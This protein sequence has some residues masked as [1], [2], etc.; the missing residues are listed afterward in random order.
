MHLEADLF[1]SKYQKP[2]VLPTVDA[3]LNHIDYIVNLVGDDFV[4]F[5]SD[6]DGIPYSCKG[7][8]NISKITNL[9]NLMERNGYSEDRINK[10]THNNVKRVLKS[11]EL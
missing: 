2:K 4:S 3:I 11:I 8:E 7:L 6:F 5:G 1:L 9:I 10:I